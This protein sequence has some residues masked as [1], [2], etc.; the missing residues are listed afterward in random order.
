MKLYTITDDPQYGEMI[1]YSDQELEAFKEAAKD[2]SIIRLDPESMKADFTDH[3][4]FELYLSCPHE[5]IPVDSYVIK[6]GELVGICIKVGSQS[7]H[8]GMGGWKPMRDAYIMFNSYK[9]SWKKS[10]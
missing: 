5:K 8:D 9:N 1:E 4:A 10:S 3:E 2:W 7:V 6:E